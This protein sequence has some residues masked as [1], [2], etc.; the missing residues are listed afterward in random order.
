MVDGG[1]CLIRSLKSLIGSL[2]SQ[3][4]F[5]ADPVPNECLQFM[6]FHWLF[7]A[8]DGML[9]FGSSC[10]CKHSEPKRAP[11]NYVYVVFLQ[12]VTSGRQQAK[13]ITQSIM[14]RFS[15]QPRCLCGTILEVVKLA[16]GLKCRKYK[17]YCYISFFI[18]YPQPNSYFSKKKEKGGAQTHLGSMITPIMHPK[19]AH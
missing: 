15:D 4:L 13:I 12:I 3:W 17:K 9:S 1:P 14:K 5:L 11:I 6:H 19:C 16:M 7:L 18:V 10:H 2:H 8:M